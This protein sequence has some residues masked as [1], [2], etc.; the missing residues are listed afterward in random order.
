VLQRDKWRPEHQRRI[1]EEH[2]DLSLRNGHG[3]VDEAAGIALI[4]WPEAAMPFRPLDT[5]AALS[6]IGR[7]L[8]AGVVLV[9]GALRVDEADIRRG[10]GRKVFNSLL[11]FGDDGTVVATYDKSHLVP[12]GEYLPAQNLLEAIGLQQLSKLRGGFASGPEPRPRLL[13]GRLGVFAPLICYEAIFPDLQI[14]P[15]E[16]PRALLNVTNDGW[17]GNSI[18]P[19][20][21]LHQARVRAVESGLPLIRAANNGI[22][23][24]IDPYGRTIAQLDLNIRGSVDARLPGAIAPPFYHRAGDALFFTLVFALLAWLLLTHAWSRPTDPY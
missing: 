10:V 23:A 13:L 15:G 4:V 7:M 21:H 22:S 5:P 16:R 3:A 8:P 14:G 19:R 1:F 12:F 2:L 17:F 11:A 6:A 9:S 24:I 18:G 20:Q